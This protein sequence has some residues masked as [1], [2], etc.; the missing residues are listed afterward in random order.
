MDFDHVTE[1]QQ[2]S[3]QKVKLENS[4]Q[5]ARN[6]AAINA[7][8]EELQR[9]GRKSVL[10]NSFEKSYP[11]DCRSDIFNSFKWTGRFN[12]IAPYFDVLF[13]I[14]GPCGSGYFK[15]PPGHYL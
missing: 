13:S 6:N 10:F 4:P 11:L 1:Q 12:H 7:L 15:Y 14:S 9:K 5:T 3:Q 2:M 8:N